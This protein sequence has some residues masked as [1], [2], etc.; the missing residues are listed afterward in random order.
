[1]ELVTDALSSDDGVY[2]ADRRSRKVADNGGRYRRG[3]CLSVT[4]M[5]CDWHGKAAAVCALYSRHVRCDVRI[6]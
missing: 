1:M 5:P 4:H 6:R 2:R 3:P